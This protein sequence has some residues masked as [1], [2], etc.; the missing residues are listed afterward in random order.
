MARV[1]TKRSPYTLLAGMLPLNTTRVKHITWIKPISERQISYVVWLLDFSVDTW[2]H[3]WIYMVSWVYVAWEEKWNC[4]RMHK[5]CLILLG[6]CWRAP[7]QEQWEEPI[8]CA[9]THE[10]QNLLH[11]LPSAST[12]WEM[13]SEVTHSCP[14]LLEMR[15]LR[16][17]RGY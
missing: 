11:L 13:I 7:H 2:S 6:E 4:L 16:P 3:A 10:P 17:S 12:E 14:I 8:S 1:W 5:G 9:C 15:K